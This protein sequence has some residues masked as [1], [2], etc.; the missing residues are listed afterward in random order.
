MTD[1]FTVLSHALSDRYALDRQIGEGGMATVYLAQDLKHKRPVAIK[2]LRPELAATIGSERFLREVE[3]AAQLQHPH[4]VPVYDSGVADGVLYYVMPFVEGE[5][6]RDRLRREGKLPLAEAVRLTREAASA[7]QYAH[8]HGI[9]HRDVKPENIMLSGGHAVVADFGIARAAAPA[10]GSERLTGMG[11]AV[12]TPAYMSTEQATADDIDAR[13]DQYSLACVF[14]EMATG[15][16]AFTGRNVQ[17]LLASHVTGPRPKLSDAG[18]TFASPEISSA[19]DAVVTRALATDREQRYPDVMQFADALEQAIHEG[20]SPRRAMWPML[21]GAVLLALVAAGAAWYARGSTPTGVKEGAERIAILPFSVTGG[22]DS[23]MGEGMA[24]LLTTNF[25]TV[26]QLRTVDPQTVFVQWRK[27]GGAR[28][29]DLKGALAIA[30]ATKASAALLGNVTNIG[31]QMR[32]S[33]TLYGLDG[34]ELGKA[35]SE[36]PADSVLSLV[37]DL[38]ARL[39]REIWKSREPL[40]SLNVAGVITGSVPALRAYLE[41]EQYYRRGVFDSA[42]AAFKRATEADS[43]FALAH[44]RLAV[45]Y[46]WLGGF[47]GGGMAAATAA[48]ERF[49]DR[50]P[51][52]EQSLV[53]AYALFRNGRPEAADSMRAYL[54]RH[55][56]DADALYQLGES[57]YHTREIRPQPPESLRVPF[58]QVLAIDSTLAPA[59]IHPMEMALSDHDSVLYAHYLTQLTAAADPAQVAGWR[60]AGDLVWRNA[61]PDEALVKSMLAAGTGSLSAAEHGL[62][63]DA[64]PP[65]DSALRIITDLHAVMRAIPGRANQ[66]NFIYGSTL[67]MLG[68]FAELQ[69]FGQG[70]LPTDQQNGYVM[71]LMPSLM[72]QAA[73]ADMKAN[74]ARG[75]EIAKKQSSPFPSLLFSIVALQVGDTAQARKLL[76]PWLSRDTTAMSGDEKAAHKLMQ[77]LDGWRLIAQGDTARGLLAMREGLDQLANR[78]GAPLKDP[79]RFQYSVTLASRPDTRAQGIRLLEYGYDFPLMQPAA[80]LALGRLYEQAGEN[81]KAIEAYARVV[82]LWATAD[83]V[84]QPKVTEA[85]EALAR[86]TAEGKRTAP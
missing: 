7:L 14:Y 45:A 75:V 56:G 39:V 3:M 23:T 15:R 55:P 25:G 54:S 24:N 20:A 19:V 9:I 81:Q 72:G 82:H 68:H 30:A 65:V 28:G 27:R 37:D 74:L 36:G 57:M 4:V 60:A 79:A 49:S 8:Q 58:E 22:G 63:D 70:L 10:V 13:S 42:A 46:G 48:A 62:L 5:S 83:A 77:V 31:S 51:P 40:P 11:I 76:Q 12:G 34:S 47:Q 86:L 85:K 26:P 71:M 80:Q 41:G 69:K 1:P 44:Y 38:S 16:Q 29:V 33:A 66:S 52:R 61:E 64:G 6:L 2:V 35:Q 59:L 67:A 17:Q 18:N 50:L 84:L 43:T 21:V 53:R 78:L 73:P 32:I